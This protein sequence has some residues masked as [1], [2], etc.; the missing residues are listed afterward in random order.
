MFAVPQ[1]IGDVKIERT[2]E[3]Y[4]CECLPSPLIDHQFL[5]DV[6]SAVIIKYFSDQLSSEGSIILVSV[7]ADADGV[8]FSKIDEIEDIWPE[9]FCS[10][11]KSF[12]IQRGNDND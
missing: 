10:L 9:Q 11:V 2:A 12:K 6:T 4:S 1:P 8:Q 5:I 7:S 3:F